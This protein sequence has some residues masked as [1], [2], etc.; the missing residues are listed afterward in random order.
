MLMQLKSHLRNEKIV[1]HMNKY[2]NI[3]YQH[4]YNVRV[5]TFISGKDY[6][7]VISDG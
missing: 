3:F 7:R 6:I 5:D 4:T 2:S 1:Y